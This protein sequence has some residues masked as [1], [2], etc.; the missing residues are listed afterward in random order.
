MLCFSQW[1]ANPSISCLKKRD[2]HEACWGFQALD[3]AGNGDPGA[4][5]STGQHWHMADS[6]GHPKGSLCSKTAFPC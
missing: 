2:G 4:P 5:L 1:D 3:S 6:H